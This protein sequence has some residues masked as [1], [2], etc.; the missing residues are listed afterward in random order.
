MPNTRTILMMSAVTMVGM[1]VANQ[2]ASRNTTAR[3][4]F[5]GQSV[6][7][8]MSAPNTQMA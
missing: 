6:S 7:G 1:F 3:R 8:T 2:L 4:V 5:K